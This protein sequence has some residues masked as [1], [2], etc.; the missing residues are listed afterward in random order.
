M[1][2]RV[3]LPLIQNVGPNQRATIRLPLGRT[4]NKITLFCNGN[5]L[6]SLLTNIVLKVNTGEKMRWKTQAHLQARNAYNLG[7]ASAGALVL[8]FLE[9]DAKDIAA[10][11]LGAYAMTAEAGVQDAVLEFD[12][13]TYTVTA[14]STIEAIAEV[15]TPSA[16][17]LIVRT[18]Y[19][20]KTLAGAV[21]EQIIIPFGRNGEQL[22]RLMIFGT[23]ASITNVRVRRDD[24]DEFES[25][26]VAQNE[27]MQRE[28]GKV[29][30]AGLM[31]VDF[32]ESNLQSNMLNTASIMG[33][34]GPILVE[35][36]D[37]RML[38]SAAGTFDIY[39]ESITANDRP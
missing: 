11:T 13:G 29:P 39:T 38:T 12:I 35:N 26:T 16:N 36:L 37:I 18:R 25:I 15:D 7:A 19:Q 8:N 5:I 9:K 1:T 31:V 4:Y 20:Q 34:K 21:E 14:G 24:S 6:A 23:L 28:Y 30:Q 10:M 2:R 17:P 32:I 27:F 3:K 22:K 33:P